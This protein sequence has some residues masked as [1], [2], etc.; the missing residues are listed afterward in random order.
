MSD[1]QPSPNRFNKVFVIGAGKTGTKT[2]LEIMQRLGL[3]VAPQEEAERNVVH[4]LL[5]G[6]IAPL[7]AYVEKYQAFQ[8]VPFSHGQTYAQ[9]D[10]L[11][12]GSKFI[13]TIR[14]PETWFRS[15]YRFAH[16]VAEHRKLP[17]P[18]RELLES[19]D[20]PY[21]GGLAD[22]V[23]ATALDFLGPLGRPVTNWHLF[24]DK[25]THIQG[26]RQRNTAIHRHFL[27]RPED[28]LVIDLSKEKDVSR[29]ARFLGLPQDVNF[30]MPHKHKTDDLAARVA[31]LR[32]GS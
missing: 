26:Y 17:K 15:F 12:P 21:P 9:V 16:L 13:L 6:D 3:N 5:R 10:A 4:P 30:A 32:D 31:A 7:K 2:C 1:A 28:L 14:D 8:D 24:L 23:R 27:F 29:I 11:F 20:Y 19:Y 18:S 25:T 22:L